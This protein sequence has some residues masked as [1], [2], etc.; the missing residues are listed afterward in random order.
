MLEISTCRTNFLLDIRKC[1]HLTQIFPPILFRFIENEDDE[2]PCDAYFN[3][4]PSSSAISVIDEQLLD[5]EQMLGMKHHLLNVSLTCLVGYISNSEYIPVILQIHIDVLDINDET[6][7][8]SVLS[9][10]HRLNLTENVGIPAVVLTLQPRDK[11]QGLNGTTLFNI[12]RGNELNYFTIDLPEGEPEDSTTTRVIVLRKN[13]NFEGMTSGV[14]NLSI[15]ISDMGE[16]PLVFVQI[17]LITVTNLQDEPPT[18][19]ITSYTFC[20]LENQTVG[21]QSDFS[22]VRASSQ[23]YAIVYSMSGNS[24]STDMV[25]VNQS[26]GGLFLRKPLDYE[27][28]RANIQFT[29]IASNPN[30]RDV[31]TVSV[32]VQVCDVNDEAPY[33]KCI[34]VGTLGCPTEDNIDG[35]EFCMSENQ[36]YTNL[37]TLEMLDEDSSP[38]FRII[39]E[40]IEHNV[41]PE[42]APLKIILSP[43]VQIFLSDGPVDRELFPNITVTLTLENIAVPSLRTNSTLI[44][45]VLDVNDNAPVFS[46]DDYRA[47]VFEG[48]PVDRKVV[49]VVATD[50]DLKENGTVSYYVSSTE[51]EEST[52]WFKISPE[53]GIISV[54]SSSISYLAVDGVV[55]LTV[56]A[57]DNGAQ[58][59]SSSVIIII[60]IIPSTTFLSNSYQEYSS[61]D[62]NLLTN[63]NHD[64]Y[65]EYTTT[66]QDG[67]LLYQQD[68]NGNV[69]S[70]QL[71][72]GAILVKTVVNEMEKMMDESSEDV[73][74]AVS[75]QRS[76]QQVNL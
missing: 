20:V 70:V 14:F 75:I 31:V 40:N 59:L 3:I 32:N 49:Q 53:D 45:Q 72:Q 21:S 62:F 8:F 35:F 47:C 39:N 51:R 28:S 66:K 7:G 24:R 10:P 27:A 4:D 25:G 17:I 1:Y 61:N 71:K 54:A 43:F 23:G 12:T 33:F 5:R 63:S 36:N 29:V 37:I 64:I 44:I 56:T 30:T 57:V 41:E 55:N 74:V 38:E 67:L 34:D 6:P 60:T 52:H 22:Y 69:F 2:V 11:D 13:L 73:W 76:E 16:I 15:T 18:F 58:R 50:K 9:Q 65:L 26:T 68:S 19:E 48:S 46:Q 42:G